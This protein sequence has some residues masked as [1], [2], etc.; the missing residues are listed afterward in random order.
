MQNLVFHIGMAKCA[1]TTLQENV[2]KYEAGSLGAYKGLEENN[3]AKKFKGLVPVSG[4]QNAELSRL[5]EWWQ[6]VQHYQ[7]GLPG[8]PDTLIISAEDLS[9]ANK[10]EQRPI[11]PILKYFAD[12][13]LTDEKL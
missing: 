12:S 13:V 8:K 7:S 6:E 3:F 4:K 5:K 2:F 10:S 9:Q 11:I 1:S